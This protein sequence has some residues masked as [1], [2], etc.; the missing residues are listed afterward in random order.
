MDPRTESEPA[1]R[2]PA[3]PAAGDTLVGIQG[4]SRP[5]EG[6]DSHGAVRTLR[7]SG[8]RAGSADA[9]R[10]RISGQVFGACPAASRARGVRVRAGDRLIGNVR[11]AR[12]LSRPSMGR[13]T[14]LFQ[15]QMHRPAGW[16]GARIAG[17]LSVRGSIGRPAWVVPSAA[18]RQRAVSWIQRTP[19]RNLD[20]SQ[21]EPESRVPARPAAATMPPRNARRE[22][23]GNRR[24]RR[25]AQPQPQMR[26]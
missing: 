1:I 17:S 16:A 23:P 21:G 15:Q 13:D 2:A 11:P 10:P 14:P 7:S 19:E 12:T 25:T 4:V 3:Q 26:T 22:A 5:F 6:L 24:R 20:G 9:S 18:R 8:W